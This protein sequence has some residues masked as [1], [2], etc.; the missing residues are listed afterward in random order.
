VPGAPRLQ[1]LRNET[2]AAPP[3]YSHAVP[4]ADHLA[5]DL[6]YGMRRLLQG[7]SFTIAAI[8]TLALGIGANSAIFT[9]VNA[10]LLRPL[11]VADPGRLYVLG[12]A[13]D[14]CVLGGV[15]EDLTEYSLPLYRQLRDHTPE[16]AE[17]AAFQAA[18]QTV[19]VRRASGA[20]AEPGRLEFVSDNYFKTFGVGA[21][22]GRTFTPADDRLNAV[23]VAVISHRAWR[24]RFG[25]DPAILGASVLLGSQAVTVVGVAPPGFFGDTLR[26]D[27][28]DFWLPLAAEQLLDRG[29]PLLPHPDT[30]WLYAIGRL[31]AT[32]A[33]P[34]VAAHVNAEI[35]QWLLAQPWLTRR[36]RDALAKTRMQ[37][38]AAPGG[39]QSRMARYREG[40]RLLTVVSGVLLLIACAN[41]ANL[42]LARGM[43]GRVQ[44]AVRM[45]LGAP[46]RRLILQTVTEGVLLAGAGGIAGLGVALAGSRVILALAFRGASF[47]PIDPNPSPAVLA[48]TALVCLA[49]GVLFSVA[50]AL[51]ASRTHPAEPLRGAMRATRAR[52][53]LPQRWL[54]VLQAALSLVLL[55][56]AGL[57]SESLRRLEGQPFGFQTA[58]RM[59][60]HVNLALAGAS[61]GRLAALYGELQRRLERLPG[62][63]S[64]GLAL[65]GPMEQMN[66][67]LPI[68][69][70]GRAIEADQSPTMDRVSAH[71]FETLGSRLLRGRP[72][73]EQD[74]PGAHHVAV[75]NEAF[76]RKF[77]PG[78][79]PIGRHLG[80]L[81]AGHGFDYEILGV[82]E[83][84]K[85][86]DARDPARAT[87]FLPLL[88]D[89]VY[90]DAEQAG[91]QTNSNRV[92]SIE[93]RVTGQP[94]GLQAA[95]RRTLADLD[96]SATVVRLVGLDE[97][98]K[99]NFNNE[100]LIARLTTLYS[101]VA[102]VLACVG[103]YGVA[104]YSVARRTREIG[105]RMALGADR[106]GVILMVLRGAMKPIALGLALGIPAALAAG[107]GLASQ[108]FG[109]H[110]YD[111][112]VLTV[113]V[114]ALATFALLAAFLPARR[115]A[116]IDPMA[117]LRSE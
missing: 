77:F 67:S 111:P 85:Y 42:L 116:S 115:S 93:L 73:G 35:R 18:P 72:I 78:Q 110:G 7:R 25:L 19:G 79:E 104:S 75:I 69:I 88:Q 83:D 8:L 47:V 52:E 44:T 21:L 101:L 11:P 61:P 103:L 87:L 70:D 9:L 49:A 6:R 32:A 46:R 71:Y 20:A 59:V 100:R 80:L 15:E 117:A 82:V 102:L 98:V 27:P 17:L 64:A 34:A 114:L 33:P 23:P 86:V 39:V 92:G 28:P 50:P 36:D 22:A 30:F 38:T 60:A 76:A 1:L 96:P 74:T 43:A 3:A 58:G 4:F 107:R 48:F 109:L 45:A 95:V 16:I 24:D 97:Q 37:L 106:G 56:G 99:R 51:I 63:V 14:C 13:V 55:A 90:A 81:G 2:R 31:R 68:A 5:Q 62:V 113:A 112:A 26:S 91:M 29:A 57:L 12:D 66:W 65:Y 54:V 105:L 94:A 84:A 89:V 10:V 108:L 41:V 40:L 53:S